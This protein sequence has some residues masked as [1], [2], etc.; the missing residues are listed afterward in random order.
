MR[1]ASSWYQKITEARPKAELTLLKFGSNFFVSLDQQRHFENWEG[2]DCS[3]ARSHTTYYFSR[4]L[5]KL[6][7]ILD[8]NE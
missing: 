2:L 5:N 1:E 7:Y 4:I 3:L 6:R 8:I